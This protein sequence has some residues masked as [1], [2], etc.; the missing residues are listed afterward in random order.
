M[1]LSSIQSPS[2]TV[3]CAQV[4]FSATTRCGPD[5]QAAREDGGHVLAHGGDVRVRAAA[6][7]SP[8]RPLVQPA[9]QVATTAVLAE[10][11]APWVAPYGACMAH[12]VRRAL[13]VARCML[14]LS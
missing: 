4:W 6:V 10:Y 3:D 2:A 13:H 1:A 12:V 7:C 11:K 14:H 5:L 9:D 8:I